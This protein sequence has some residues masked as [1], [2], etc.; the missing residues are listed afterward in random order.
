MARYR[1]AQVDEIAPAAC[2][3]GLSRRA[4]AGEDGAAASVHVTDIT[5]EARVHYHKKLTEVY[6]IL[7]GEGHMELDGRRVPVRPMTAVLVE[8]LCRHRAVGNIR[9]AIFV[10]PPFEAADEWFD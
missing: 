2:P 7:A 4:F 1:F 8:P 10:T 6:L 3:C 9:A 5:A